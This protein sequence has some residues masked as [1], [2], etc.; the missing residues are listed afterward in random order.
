MDIETLNVGWV[1]GRSVNV[2]E[3]KIIDIIDNAFPDQSDPTGVQYEV[4]K[5]KSSRR[6]RRNGLGYVGICTKVQFARWA[7]FVVSRPDTPP[8]KVNQ[9]MIDRLV[10][11]QSGDDQP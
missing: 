10:K 2:T 8:A 3:R 1:Y 5:H 7:H 6:G 4:V 11:K 9:S